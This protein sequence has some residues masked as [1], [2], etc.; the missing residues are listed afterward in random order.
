LI[1]ER[2]A[3]ATEFKTLGSAKRMT[4]M[5]ADAIFGQENAITARSLR[6]FMVEQEETDNWL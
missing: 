1:A 2:A 6:P 4:E 5:A 3:I